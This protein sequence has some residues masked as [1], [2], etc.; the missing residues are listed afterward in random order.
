M[1]GIRSKRS[2]M[3]EMISWPSDG[4]VAG[5][6]CSLCEWRF[7]IQKPLTPETPL[8]FQQRIARRWYDGHDCQQ[9][10]P[11][12]KAGRQQDVEIPPTLMF[13]RV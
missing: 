8:E 11:S 9:F 5:F 1:R 3:R 7:H 4:A 10:L 12:A 2:P 6:F 13:H